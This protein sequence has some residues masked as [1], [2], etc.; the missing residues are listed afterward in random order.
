M[1]TKYLHVVVVGVEPLLHL[2][3]LDINLL[4]GLGGRLLDTTANGKVAL[5]ALG[6]VAETLGDDVEHDRVVKDVIVEG[7]VA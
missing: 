2:L 7:E 6:K 4:L 3:G 1:K 5:M